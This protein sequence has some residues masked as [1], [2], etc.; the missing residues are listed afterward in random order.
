MLWIYKKEEKPVSDLLHINALL[1]NFNK[2]FNVY[3]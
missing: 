1:F 3:K 2:V